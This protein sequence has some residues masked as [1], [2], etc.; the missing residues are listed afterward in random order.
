MMIEEDHA[1]ILWDSVAFNPS[2]RQLSERYG[3]GEVLNEPE[4]LS[5]G[6]LH[7]MWFLST[8]GGN[9]AL[10]EINERNW[11]LLENTILPVNQAEQL[12]LHHQQQGLLTRVALKS[13]NHRHIERCDQNQA[14]MLFPWIEGTMKNPSD[15]T[16]DDAQKIGYL[17]NKIQS[18]APM[19]NNLKSPQWFGFEQ[20]HWETLIQKAEDQGLPWAVLARSH[21]AVLNH[22]S[23]EASKAADELKK[24]LITSHR[25][26]SFSNVVWQPD[27]LPVVIDWEYAGLVN[28]ES[29]RFNTA[30]TWSYRGEGIFDSEAFKA[31]ICGTQSPFTL[32]KSTLF[33]GYAGYLLEWCEFNMRRSLLES[34][35]CQMSSSEVSS[36]L[37][38]LNDSVIDML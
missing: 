21:Q 7:G 9:Y 6:S 22:W 14:W 32:D 20:N 38:I 36:I 33:A 16:V 13:S 2:L 23:F 11:T 35:T 37:H 10:K 24:N 1:E 26:L 30:M 4:K 28:P 18:V 34:T 17:L 15:I 25:D 27:G 8:S 29:E 12:A 31:F 5:G 3:I 19:I